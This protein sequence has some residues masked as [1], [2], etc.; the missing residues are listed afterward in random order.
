[1]SFDANCSIDSL[2]EKVLAEISPEII[3]LLGPKDMKD[4]FNQYHLEQ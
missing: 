3:L 2:H 1:M 4:N